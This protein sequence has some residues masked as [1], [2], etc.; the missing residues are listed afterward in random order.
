MPPALRSAKGGPAIVAVLVVMLTMTRVQ[1]QWRDGF[2]SPESAWTDIGGDARYRIEVQQRVQAGAHSGSGCEYLQIATLAAGRSALMSY[3]LGRAPII[4]ELRPSVWVRS[5]RNGIQLLARVVFPRALDPTSNQ[6]LTALIAGDIYAAAGQ[7]QELR[8]DNLPTVLQRQ[9]WVMR[10]QLK[11][12]ID[13]R[14]AFIDRIVLNVYTGAA[15]TS[16]WIDDLTVEGIVPSGPP[17]EERLPLV[18]TDGRN[19]YE[20]SHRAMVELNGSVLLADGRPLF[21]RA[22]DYRGEP[23][24]LIRGLGFNAVR[25]TSPPNRAARRGAAR[26]IVDCQPAADR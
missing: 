24:A 22:V 8:I 13:V 12:D 16:L 9:T 23:L 3:A 20:A 1:A 15:R 4:P 25:L 18:G 6:P 19:I 14:E 17:V 26:R 7:W 21:P 11:R 5:D 2:E 10:T